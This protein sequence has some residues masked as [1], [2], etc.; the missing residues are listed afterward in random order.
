[1]PTTAFFID[2]RHQ[3]FN[4][5]NQ[6]GGNQYVDHQDHKLHLEFYSYP[7]A[8][9]KHDKTFQERLW[10]Q[11]QRLWRITTETS[12]ARR[13]RPV[14]TFPLHGPFTKIRSPTSSMALS[15]ERAITNTT[16]VAY[17]H[18]Q[19]CQSCLDLLQNQ[20]HTTSHRVW[21]SWSG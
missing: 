12:T 5:S 17:I 21:W 8:T 3:R 4:C 19:P 15:W 1:M 2:W 13:G 11:K 10:Y 20:C 7:E 18:L 6:L 16:C 9:Q 14:V